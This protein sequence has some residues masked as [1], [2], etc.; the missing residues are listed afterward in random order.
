VPCGRLQ[1]RI[2]R[3]DA[4]SVLDLTGCEYAASGV[5]DKPLILTGATI[6]PPLGSPGLLVSADDV[7]I[8]A[9][10]LLG[11][12]GRT[13]QRNTTGI[14]VD[15]APGSPVRSLSITDSEIRDF[16]NCIRIRNVEEPYIAGNTI[17][18]CV[19][20]GVMALSA[21]GGI[22]EDNEIRRIGVVGAEDNDGNA[23]GIAVSH[24][25]EDDPASSDVTVRGN[26]VEDV[27]TWHALDTHGGSRILFFR[28]EISGSSRAIFIT[29][30]PN[31][32]RSTTIGI[33]SNL[34]TAPSDPTPNDY[35]ITTFDS[36]DVTIRWNT[37]IGWPD[38]HFVNDYQDRSSSL[39]VGENTILS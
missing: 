37:A 11:P 16:S 2:D 24:Q 7:A 21:T 18:D 36:V 20:A 1:Q 10:R 25:F 35:A 30:G 34:L 29:G 5:I 3:A 13:W 32:A 22:I 39:N 27:P 6:R 15:E 26:I 28:N 9:I 23:Y 31:G 38:D 19:Y 8:H 17:E 33:E 4:G 12:D 14:S